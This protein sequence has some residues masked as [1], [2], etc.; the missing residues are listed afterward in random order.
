MDEATWEELRRH[1][2]ERQTTELV[3]LTAFIGYFNT[4]AVALQIESDGF[5]ALPRASPLGGLPVRNA[6]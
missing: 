1:F 4:M 2:D 6:G 5:C 3:W